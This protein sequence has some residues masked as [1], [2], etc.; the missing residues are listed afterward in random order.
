LHSL[1]RVVI[2][3]RIRARA[4]DI[5]QR[6]GISVENPTFRVTA[7][8]ILDLIRVGGLIGLIDSVIYLFFKVHSLG[9]DLFTLNINFVNTFGKSLNGIVDLTGQALD[10]VIAFTWSFEDLFLAG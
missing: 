8:G 1:R 3:I 6:I 5:A 9:I 4:I 7:V 2:A 10:L